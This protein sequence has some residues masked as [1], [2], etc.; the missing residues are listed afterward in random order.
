MDERRLRL[1]CGSRFEH[2]NH[3][4]DLM[5]F[6]LT[7]LAGR[8]L[9]GWTPALSRSVV[10]VGYSDLLTAWLKS[11]SHPEASKIDSLMLISMVGCD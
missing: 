5:E 11:G 9:G 8:N 6:R 2:S 10:L 4:T 7:L 1:F 3:L